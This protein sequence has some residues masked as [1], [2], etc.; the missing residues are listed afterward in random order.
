MF[1]DSIKLLLRGSHIEVLK[2][3]LLV[4]ANLKALHFPMFGILLKFNLQMTITLYSL[5][6]QMTE[7]SLHKKFCYRSVYPYGFQL[8]TI[9]LPSMSLMGVLGG[10]ILQTVYIYL[11]STLM[12]IPVIRTTLLYLYISP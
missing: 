12:D 10:F 6:R 7:L 5:N 9:K 2:K 3:M 1:S 8:L 4:Q 11:Q